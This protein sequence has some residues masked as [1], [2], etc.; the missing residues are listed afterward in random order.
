MT[1]ARS[2]PLRLQPELNQAA[3]RAEPVAQREAT[4]ALS[5]GMDPPVQSHCYL[6]F[7][8]GRSTRTSRNS[9]GSLIKR[10]FRLAFSSLFGAPDV[11]LSIAF[12]A[13]SFARSAVAAVVCFGLP[14]TVSP[15]STRRWMASERER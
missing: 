6:P 1:R 10:R 5:H 2:F 3:A 9:S 7:A 11:K 13:S 8:F 15:S 12:E 14:P 4:A